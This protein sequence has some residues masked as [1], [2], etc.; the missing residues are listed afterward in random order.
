LGYAGLVAVLPLAALL[1][2]LGRRL[3]WL[4]D[5]GSVA[6]AVVLVVLATSPDRHLTRVDTPSP[7]LRQLA[8]LVGDRVP[9]GAH[10]AVQR[11]YGTEQRN[12]GV[13]APSFWLAWPSGR[14]VANMFNVESSPLGGDLAF[15]ADRMTRRPRPTS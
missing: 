6:C 1:G 8:A 11:A 3:G 9:A 15:A 7:Q 4:G 12:T 2:H 14:E 10:F 13:S 5:L